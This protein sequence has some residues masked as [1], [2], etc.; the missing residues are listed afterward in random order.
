MV[1]A[2][3]ETEGYSVFVVRKLSDR[4]DEIEKGKDVIGGNAQGTEG[5]F[6]LNGLQGVGVLPECEADM[7]ALE[8]GD[9]VGRAGAMENT[10]NN[11]TVNRE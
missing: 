7:F 9:P 11:V 6:D 5:D 10:L 2:E 1:L 8:L 3:A 4:E